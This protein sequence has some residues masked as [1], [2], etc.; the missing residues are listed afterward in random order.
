MDGLWWWEVG[1]EWWYFDEA[2]PTA[3]KLVVVLCL[4]CIAGLLSLGQCVIGL[5]AALPPQK[6]G[7]KQA[8]CMG[9]MASM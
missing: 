8:W 9:A 7:K 6:S 5:V 3:Q 2:R 1:Y 4:E